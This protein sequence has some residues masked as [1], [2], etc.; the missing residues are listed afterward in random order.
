MEENQRSQI[1]HLLFQVLRSIYH[2]ERKIITEHGLDFDQIYV[3]Q[4]LR[5]HPDTRFT[6]ITEEIVLPKFTASRLISRLVKAGFI[7]RKQDQ[8]DR[9]NFFLHLEEKGEQVIQAI[10]TASFSRISANIQGYTPDQIK[11]L[12][13]AAE[14]L[15][16][17]LGVSNQVNN[18]V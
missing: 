8:E 11:E 10:E 6:E 18:Q 5:R 13:D 2:Y 7:S 3:L 14:H 12:F 1:D 16:L 17:V 15:P 9:R 4:Y